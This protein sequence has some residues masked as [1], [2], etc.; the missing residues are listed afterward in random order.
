MPVMDYRTQVGASASVP[1]IF[2][3][4][5]FSVMRRPSRCRVYGR[6]PTGQGTLLVSISHTGQVEARSIGMTVGAG[7]PSKPD[8]LLAEFGMNVGE[9]LKVD[10][11]ETGAVATTPFIQVFIDE[12]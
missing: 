8:D 9:K 5:D 4:E 6:Y 12:A 7:A 2:N 3:P 1:D 11:A 10:L